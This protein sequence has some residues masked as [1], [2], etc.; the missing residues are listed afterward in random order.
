MK[1]QSTDRDTKFIA[2]IERISG[3]KLADCY[4][5]GK[6]SAGCPIGYEMDML[7]DKVMRY[8]QLGIKD[9]VIDSQTPW[10]CASCEQCSS[11]CPQE[12]EIP[13]VMEAIRIIGI[14]EGKKKGGKVAL[15]NNLFAGVIRWFGRSYEPGL[16]GFYNLLS[17]CWLQDAKNAVILIAKG[18]I[19]FI[20]KPAKCVPQVQK[21]MD[22][23]KSVK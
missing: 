5:C 3:Q 20:P 7:P 1:T 21:M 6:C 22:Q 13:R 11:R 18:K 19:A 14:R 17:G 2:E 23:T 4:Q 16:M 10:L 9:E 8:L 15:F 12:V